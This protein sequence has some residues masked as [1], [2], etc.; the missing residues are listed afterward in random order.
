MK[1]SITIITIALLA[2]L[3]LATSVNAAN[4][5]VSKTDVKAGDTVEVTLKLDSASHSLEYELTY[6][7][8]LF[9]YTS[10]TTPEGW[11][12]AV[13]TK[14]AGLV[15]VSGASAT[16]TTDKMTITFTA[17]KDGSASFKAD[18]LVTEENA[19]GK[20]EE[21]AVKEVAVTVEQKDA[22]PETTPEPETTT[23]PTET[24]KAGTTTAKNNSTSNPKTGDN[25][26]L[27]AGLAVVAIVAVA[28]VAKKYT[29]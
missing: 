12:M 11:S 1:K 10:H 28:F 16:N 14:T 4:L 21:L 9:E 29:K 20:M 23:K 27:Y 8:D 18:E 3:A 25:V 5:Q 19:E 15:I 26:V 24:A 7:A 22:A 13:G 2:I 6:D 17:K